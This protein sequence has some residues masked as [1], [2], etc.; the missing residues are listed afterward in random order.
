M[1]VRLG[2]GVR[3]GVNDAV[4]VDEGV[5]V[6][7][8]SGVSVGALVAVAVAVGIGEGRAS[9][10]R[11]SGPPAFVPVVIS[12][13]AVGVGTMYAAI[14]PS[15]PSSSKGRYMPTRVPNAAAVKVKP[16]TKTKKARPKKNVDSR[17]VHRLA[18]SRSPSDFLAACRS[19]RNSSSE[20]RDCSSLR[21]MLLDHPLWQGPSTI[22]CL[23]RYRQSIRDCRSAI[24]IDHVPRS[25]PT[26]LQSG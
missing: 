1:G 6:C 24:W 22:A 11:V 13:G 3:D 8:G 18:R 14:S 2:V 10:V 25:T 26:K 23:Y 16:V 7:V 5:G 15:R 12:L 19:L 17:L 20:K 21:C 4:G 9:V